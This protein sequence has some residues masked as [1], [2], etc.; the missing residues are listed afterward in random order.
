MIFN[1]GDYEKE[2][3]WIKKE[4]HIDVEKAWKALRAEIETAPAERVKGEVK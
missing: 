4:V 1:N 2:K 3:A